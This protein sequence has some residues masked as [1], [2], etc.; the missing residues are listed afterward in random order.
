MT[1]ETIA[2]PLINPVT[3][4][5][6]SVRDFKAKGQ[7]QREINVTDSGVSITVFTVTGKVYNHVVTVTGSDYAKQLVAHGVMSVVANAVAG[8]FKE[9]AEEFDLA[10]EQ[11]WG[12]IVNEVVVVREP[13]TGGVRGYGDLIRAVS[14]LRQ[15]AKDSGNEAF[16]DVDASLEATKAFI[17]GNSDE[18]NKDFLGKA[19]VKSLINKYKAERATAKAAKT[20]GDAGVDTF[21]DL[22]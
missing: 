3:F 10:L 1:T 22:I 15:A 17:L 20:S 5:D 8:T 11:A 12:N 14:E 9:S 18:K 21:A 4:A 19:A 13:A 2:T 16:A 7:I 6:G